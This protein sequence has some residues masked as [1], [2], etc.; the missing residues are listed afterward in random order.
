[1]DVEFYQRN[2]LVNDRFER[3]LYAN[4]TAGCHAAALV[5][6]ASDDAE[7]AVNALKIELH[8]RLAAVHS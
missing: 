4:C 2:V 8:K 7:W 1:M 3:V 6:Q 5:I